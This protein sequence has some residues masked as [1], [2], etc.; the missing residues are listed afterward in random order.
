MVKNNKN[1]YLTLKDYYIDFKALFRKRKKKN[2]MFKI[3]F[4]FIF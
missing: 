4:Y 3:K 1:I 2:V